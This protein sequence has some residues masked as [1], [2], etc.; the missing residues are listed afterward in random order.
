LTST[1]PKSVRQRLLSDLE[2]LA[3]KLPNGLLTRLV[4]D[5]NE[6][7]SVNMGKRN[8]RQAA[9][10]EAKNSARRTAQQKF[11]EQWWAEQRKF[12]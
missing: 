5:A 2:K 11:E 10:F 9:R 6:F 4:L 3:K 8:A 1:D 12:Y 7:H